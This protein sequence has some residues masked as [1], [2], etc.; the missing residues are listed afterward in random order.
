M[1]TRQERILISKTA[2]KYPN[3]FGFSYFSD[4]KISNRDI[5]VKR[6]L[7]EP[8]KCAKFGWPVVLLAMVRSKK[9]KEKITS[10]FL[11]KSTSDIAKSII[12]QSEIGNFYNQRIFVYC[13]IL[14]EN[15]KEISKRINKLKDDSWQIVMYVTN[16]SYTVL[17][18]LTFM[19][20]MTKTN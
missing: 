5:A 10:E 3:G 8:Q 7:Q 16:Q 17:I 15:P 1:L 9:T 13:S 4:T 18:D 20:T 14:D 11:K 2:Q 12:S 19:T 6:I